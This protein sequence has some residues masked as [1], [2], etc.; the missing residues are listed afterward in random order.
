M[1]KIKLDWYPVFYLSLEKIIHK[2]QYNIN[3][4]TNFC[5]LLKTK[6]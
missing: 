6:N 4:E 3:I 5:N 1:K 2:T